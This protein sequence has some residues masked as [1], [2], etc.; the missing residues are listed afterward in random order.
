MSVQRID[1]AR[2]ALPSSVRAAVHTLGVTQIVSWGTTFYAPAV[3]S[4]PIIA[5]TGWSKTEVYAAFSASLVLGALIARRVGQ[6]IDQRGGRNAMSLGSVLCALGLLGV[7]AA[8]SYTVYFAAW[9]LLGVA[10]R[11]SLYEAA[12]ATLTAAA[13]HEAR[14]AISVLTL[15]GGFASTVFWPIGFWLVEAQGWRMALVV[16]AACNLAICLPL[17]LFLLPRGG[18]APIVRDGP[19]AAPVD[20]SRILT[21]RERTIALWTLSTAFA[22]FSF[23]SSAFSAHLIDLLAALGLS[24]PAA[25]ATASL[26]GVGQ[27]GARLWELLFAARLGPLALSALALGLTAVAFVPLTAGVGAITAPLFTLMQGAGNGL[28]TIARGVAPLILF[29]PQGYGALTGAMAAPSLVAAAFAPAVHAA[30]VDLAGNRV[31]LVFEAAVASLSVVL[32]LLL[33]LRLRRT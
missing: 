5:E 31:G 29:G 13:R 17:H 4:A 6:F 3:F 28:V 7:A 22:L 25:V 19:R 21:G 8:H 12:F 11:L 24:D 30:I 20:T 23:M 27:V 9:L 16:F 26:R 1:L 14:R 10:M 15:Y 2:L 33:A 18:P 32:V